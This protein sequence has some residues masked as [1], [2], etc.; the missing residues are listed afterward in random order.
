LVGCEGDWGG[1]VAGWLAGLTGASNN[2]WKPRAPIS[3]TL[4]TN[5]SPGLGIAIWSPGASQPARPACTPQIPHAPRLRP[6]Y[7][8][9]SHPAT[10][11]CIKTN[12]FLLFCHNFH[13]RIQFKNGFHHQ[14]CDIFTHNLRSIV[15]IFFWVFEFKILHD[16]RYPDNRFVWP[17]LQVCIS[18][19]LYD[20]DCRF[21]WSRI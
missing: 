19:V 10:H 6:F 11:A 20:L 8:S 3:L 21:K 5:R 1:H 15:D 12:N 9:T 16:H 17:R 7:Q 4:T 13:T 2:Y 14:I 18:A